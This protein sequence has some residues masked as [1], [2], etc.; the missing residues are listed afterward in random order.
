MSLN[1]ILCLFVAILCPALGH[2]NA[3]V[4]SLQPPAWVER[5][6]SRIAIT[7]GMALSTADQ[8][9]T[10]GGGK[11]LLKLS[12]GS[13]VKLGENVALEVERLAPAGNADDTS[14]FKAVLNVIRGAFR[15]TTTELGQNRK[16]DL[17]IQ[18]GT[19]TIGI[20]GT[21]VWGKASTANDFVVLLEGKIELERNNAQTVVMDKPLT[22]Y[23]APRN[24]DAKPVEAVDMDKLAIWAQET[25][26]DAGKGVIT[27]D[28]RYRVYLASYQSDVLAEETVRK[29]QQLGYALEKQLVN[30]NGWN[31]IRLGVK[32]FASEADASYFRQMASQR[33][34]IEDAWI[35]M[36]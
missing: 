12:E 31:W 29:F 9:N 32:G 17:Q 30:V 13:D 3:V 35:D 25:E 21:D 16:R 33:F 2:A 19:A 15:F 28:G 4:D 5:N 14:V 10:G 11:V 27:G 23:D 36:R 26:L 18:V 24:S 1:R 8:L 7:P 22:I 34:G 20:R 6:N